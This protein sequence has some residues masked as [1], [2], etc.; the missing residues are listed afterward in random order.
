MTTTGYATAAE[1]HPRMG[2]IM[3]EAG[4]ILASSIIATVQL[5]FDMVAAAQQMSHGTFAV[6][7]TASTGKAHLLFQKL[8]AARM[9]RR[10]Y[11]PSLRVVTAP[12]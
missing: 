2:I 12:S 1:A 10:K 3:M 6:R 9:E 5:I 8:T 7:G 11:S 4:D